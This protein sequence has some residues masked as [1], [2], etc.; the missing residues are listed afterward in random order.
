M[1]FAG[2]SIFLPVCLGIPGSVA[3]LCCTD[4]MIFPR[5]CMFYLGTRDTLETAMNLGVGGASFLARSD[6]AQ[7]RIVGQTWIHSISWQYLDPSL[8]FFLSF[9]HIPAVAPT[10]A[11]SYFIP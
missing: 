3:L 8:L 2:K 6:V 4:S 10:R 5:L 9:V 11:R 7:L 1:E